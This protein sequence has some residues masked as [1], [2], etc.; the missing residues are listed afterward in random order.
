MSKAKSQ[1]SQK[2][3]RVVKLTVTATITPPEGIELTDEEAISL[4]MSCVHQFFEV[5]CRRDASKPL[6]WAKVY[7]EVSDS[8]CEIEE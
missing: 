5:D 2:R 1:N 8:D 6:A 3:D 7:A 4:S